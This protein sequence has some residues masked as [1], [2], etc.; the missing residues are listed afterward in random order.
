MASDTGVD[1]ITASTCSGR[2]LAAQSP[3]QPAI[4]TVAASA[5]NQGSARGVFLPHTAANERR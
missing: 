4:H 3:R 2:A 1:T 5:P